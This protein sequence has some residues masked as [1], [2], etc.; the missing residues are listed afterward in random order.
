MNETLKT[1]IISLHF[2][3]FLSASIPLLPWS[4]GHFQALD[5]SEFCKYL[6]KP[7]PGGIC[8]FLCNIFCDFLK[9]E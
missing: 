6:C 3:M 5:D 2:K 4:L 9:N 7:L 8:L 1:C